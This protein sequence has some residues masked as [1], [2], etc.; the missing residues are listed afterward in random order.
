MPLLDA[1]ARGLP[2][3][4]SNVS[5]M[6]EVVGDAGFLVDPRDTASIAAGLA[7]AHVGYG[8]AGTARTRRT[9]A[10]TEL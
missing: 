9:S 4:T 5:A 2:V 6:P 3:L 7:P 1:M 8:I 10:G